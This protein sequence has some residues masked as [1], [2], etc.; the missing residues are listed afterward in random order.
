MV[1]GD[2]VSLNSEFK[3]GP[4]QIDSFGYVLNINSYKI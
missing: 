3:Y 4:K 1:V 2:I